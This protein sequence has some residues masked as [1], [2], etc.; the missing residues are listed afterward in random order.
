[1]NKDIKL[2]RITV[3]RLPDNQ[4]GASLMALDNLEELISKYESIEQSYLEL[5]ED[6]QLGTLF[7]PRNMPEE[8]YLE[9][10]EQD[11]KDYRNGIAKLPEYES[12]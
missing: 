7:I 5:Q 8:I 3:S 4:A 9:K 6:N 10:V 12:A 11:L 2:L 1:M